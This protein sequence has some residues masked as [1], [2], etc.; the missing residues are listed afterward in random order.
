MLQAYMDESGSHDESSRCLVAGYWGEVNE[1][2]QFERAWRAVLESEGVP[3]FHAKNFWPRPRVREFAE[4]SDARHAHFIDRLLTIIQSHEIY[5]FGCGVDIGEWKKIPEKFKRVFSGYHHNQAVKDKRLKPLFLPFQFVAVRIAT[6]CQA[7]VT[8]NFVF[9]QSQQ[10][11]AQLAKCFSDLKLEARESDDPLLNHLGELSFADS[12]RTLPLQA[13]DLLSYEVY[14]LNKRMI[15]S[16]GNVSARRETLRAMARMKSTEDFWLF[17]ETRFK[18]LM[19]ILEANR[20]RMIA[21]K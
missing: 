4:W 13:A 12:H 14:R 19:E 6:Y 7:G 3:E 1:W 15:T 10:T 21:G 18:N 17:D 2:R 5:P 9:D 20:E 11:S 16:G 8:M